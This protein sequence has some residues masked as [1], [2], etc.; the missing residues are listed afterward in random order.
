MKIL[1]IRCPDRGKKREGSYNHEWN[2]DYSTSLGLINGLVEYDI[3][4]DVSIGM[5][6]G[7]STGKFPFKAAG[8]RGYFTKDDYTSAYLKNDIKVRGFEMKTFWNH[9]RTDYI[10]PLLDTKAIMNSLE[11]EASYNFELIDSHDTTLGGGVRYDYCK[12]NLWGRVVSPKDSLGWYGYLRDDWEITEKL[13]LIGTG[14]LDYNEHS[15]T[16]LTGRLSA[17]YKL[18]DDQN[19][20]VSAGNSFRAPSFTEYFMDLP[21]RTSTPTIS[22]GYADLPV[23]K[24][25]T[26]EAG[27]VGQ[28]LDKKLK[29]S[30]DFFYTYYHN[31]IDPVGKIIFNPG[32]TLLSEYTVRGNA[33]TYGCE[34]SVEY[35]VFDWMKVFG[36]HSYQLINF[37]DLAYI[38]ATPKNKFNFGM[39]INYEDKLKAA[40]YWHIM[41]KTEIVTGGVGATKNHLERYDTLNGK[42]TYAITENIEIGVECTNMLLNKHREMVTG[43]QIGR[44]VMGEMTVKF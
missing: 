4:E 6:G 38:R 29:I 32:V 19:L 43:E 40:L 26:F 15:G 3:E 17:L 2:E 36:N 21:I 44:R 22:R 20:T 34:T 1:V 27:Y 42:I 10:A 28:F 33:S 11:S 9:L 37:E 25:V 7:F 23:E 35:K 18:F 39:M 30:E 5:S 31:I 14:R 8:V 12:S 13:R 41:A 24:V 16:N